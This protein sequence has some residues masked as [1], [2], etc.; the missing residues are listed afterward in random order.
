MYQIKTSNALYRNLIN[1]KMDYNT[2][3]IRQRW[4]S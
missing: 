2:L 4:L 1:K 3:H